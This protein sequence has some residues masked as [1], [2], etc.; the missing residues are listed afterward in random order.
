MSDEYLQELLREKD[1]LDADTFVHSIRLIENEILLATKA[2]GRGNEAA[3]HSDSENSSRKPKYRTYTGAVVT[4]EIVKLSEKVVVPVKEYPK[5]NFVGKLLGPRGNTLKRMQQATQTRMSVLGRGSTRDKE[6]EEDLRSSGDAK[7][8]HLKDPLHVLIEVEAPKSEAHARLA[9]ALAEIKKYMVPEN[10]DIRQEQ[11]RE[12]A[13]LNSFGQNA[14]GSALSAGA[15]MMEARGRGMAAPI[16]RVGIPPPGAI[17]L[18]GQSLRG[19]VPRVMAVGGRSMR[20]PRHGN[21]APDQYGYDAYEATYES[22]YEGYPE[23]REAVYYEYED[24]YPVAS[25]GVRRRPDKKHQPQGGSYDE[26]K[27]QRYRTTERYADVSYPS[28]D[29]DPYRSASMR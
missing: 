27:R 19:R 2:E 28:A 23:S 21:P 8:E 4:E 9:A 18:N 3:S 11:M 17:I 22:A 29:K 12:M 15:Q 5:F 14:D 1:L 26:G 16:V 20:L 10:D 6:K 7:Y 13:L 24:E 25:S